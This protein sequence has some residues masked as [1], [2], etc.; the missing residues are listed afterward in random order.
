MENIK[1][2]DIENKFVENPQWKCKGPYTELNSLLG[3]IHDVSV[4]LLWA[5]VCSFVRFKLLN[6]QSITQSI[7]QFNIQN[8]K[9]K[10]RI[11]FP[12]P[13]N[14]LWAWP[15][16]TCWNILEPWYSQQCDPCCKDEWS[17]QRRQAPVTKEP[18][19]GWHHEEWTSHSHEDSDQEGLPG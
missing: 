7:N 15:T 9:K 14:D 1:L 19:Q 3:F 5:T 11:W 17:G 2:E 12:E 10:R 16:S 4:F 13:P 8:K 6:N 18:L